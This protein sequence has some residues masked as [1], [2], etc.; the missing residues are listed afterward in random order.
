MAGA[1]ACSWLAKTRN[2]FSL[3][4]PV[5]GMGPR[6]TERTGNLLM[7]TMAPRKHTLLVHRPR[8]DLRPPNCHS[9]VTVLHEGRMLCQGSM[10]EVQNNPKVI[11]VYLG[12][13]KEEGEHHGTNGTNGTAGPHKPGM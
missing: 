2:S 11:E 8:H 4:E 10:K 13:H 12:Q 1:S 7:A 6:G 9:K 5:A 3:D